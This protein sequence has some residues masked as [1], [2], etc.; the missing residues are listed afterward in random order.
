[1][2]E[3]IV[4]KKL[5][6][7]IRRWENNPALRCYTVM[8]LLKLYIGM[9]INQFMDKDGR[10]QCKDF[11][12]VAHAMHSRNPREMIET[13]VRSESFVCEKCDSANMN[14]YGIM[15]FA[16]PLFAP[17]SH[18]K[19]P[20]S[21]AKG[22]TSPISDLN[23]PISDSVSGEFHLFNKDIKD[24]SNIPS[25]GIACT[26]ASD[27]SGVAPAVRKLLNN[28]DIRKKML[29]AV[30][31]AV[32]KCVERHGD[33]FLSTS[34]E[35]Q[36]AWAANIIASKHCANALAK[37]ANEAIKSLESESFAPAKLEHPHGE[38]EYCYPGH[39][40]RYFDY[41]GYANPI[42]A[43]APDRPSPTATWNKFMRQWRELGN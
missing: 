38:H 26:H 1:M 7:E 18:A 30:M 39:P 41:K 42:P 10:I 12:K 14:I 23:S 11:N 29:T 4:L 15:W 33:K 27:S 13:V 25:G 2:K 16:S 21:Q 28:P 32:E 43:D 37:K 24:F 22:Q 5:Y 19:E 40:Q 31:Q 35:G 3:I 8:R 36:E 9:G 6:A 20:S 17:S 34:E